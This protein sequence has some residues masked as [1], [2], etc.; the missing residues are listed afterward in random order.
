MYILH[1]IYPIII[2]QLYKFCW[3]TKYLRKNINRKIVTFWLLGL[4]KPPAPAWCL[5]SGWCLLQHHHYSTIYSCI[6]LFLSP[7]SR[8]HFMT[9]NPILTI[10]AS[11]ETPCLCVGMNPRC[12]AVRKESALSLFAPEEV[13]QL[14]FLSFPVDQIRKLQIYKLWMQY[15]PFLLRKLMEAK[16]CSCLSIRSVLAEPLLLGL[17][18]SISSP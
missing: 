15:G 7:V 1:Y 16:H 18:F 3:Y 14:P 17:W 6:T 13:L 11:L 2:C 10:L 4:P 8:S 12:A 9:Q 5:G